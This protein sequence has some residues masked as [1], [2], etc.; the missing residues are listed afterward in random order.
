MPA[1]RVTVPES[2]VALMAV[3]KMHPVELLME[4][5]TAGQRLFG[6]NR[7]QEFQVK[8]VGNGRNPESFGSAEVPPGSDL[9]KI[10]RQQGR[11]SYST[12]WTQSTSFKTAQRLA[13]TST[14]LG[15][16]MP[17]LLEVKL[18]DEVSKHGM[19]PSEVPA[20]LEELMDVKGI[21]VRGLM[22]VPPWS[23]D[24]E[25]ARPYFRQLRELRDRLQAKHARLT[26]LSMGMS[27]RFYR[28]NRGRFHLRTNW[29]G[30]L[31]QAQI[32]R[33]VSKN[34]VA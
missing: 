9:C 18:S 13:N 28:C 14:E 34:R 21:E 10:I 12:R 11:P 25:L 20:L 5:Y 32:R 1:G 30:N 16:V 2:D 33:G 19:A 31:W 23:E 8:S 15:R 24:P 17:I 22:T 4:A 3:S 26:Q 27:K 29:H 6:E 7:V